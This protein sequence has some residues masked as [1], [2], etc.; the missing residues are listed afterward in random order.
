MEMKNKK[1]KT[2]K[3]MEMNEIK[4]QVEDLGSETIKEQEP[5]QEV[6]LNPEE[7]LKV[8]LA[9]AND[10]YIR[11]VAEFDNYRKR[12]IKERMELFQTA[13]KEVLTA[14]LPVM[15]DFE[16][17]AKTL[18]SAT[19]IAAVKEGLLLIQHK[20]KSIMTQ[21]GIVEMNSLG[22]KFDADLHE[23]IT[24]IP[25]PTEDMKGKIV[26]EVEKGYYLHE[27]LIRHAKVIVG[28]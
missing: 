27:K 3:D 8:E 25:A 17:G 22:Q 26:D 2:H 7:I 18:E 13:G 11:L 15:D 20:L 4:D 23:A 14:L 9:E 1:T 10:K 19:D 28:S 5:V 16:R 12:T 6:E 21:K 24:S